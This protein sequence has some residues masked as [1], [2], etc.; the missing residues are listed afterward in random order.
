MAKTKTKKKIYCIVGDA[1]ASK[2]S[3]IRALTGVR[4]TG[5]TDV[6]F[7]NNKRNTFYV[8]VTSMQEETKHTIPKAI[9]LLKVENCD[10]NLIALRFKKVGNYPCAE[11]YLKAFIKKG[12]AI[13]GIA[14]LGNQLFEDNNLNKLVIRIT[15]PFDNAINK[16]ASIIREVWGL[17]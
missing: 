14:M 10:Y 13:E 2:S 16:N 8:K 7:V 5:K 11:D 6:C 3:V 9:S 15:K 17:Y 12:W 4:I 1:N